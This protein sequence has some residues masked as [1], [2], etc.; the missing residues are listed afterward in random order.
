MFE[1]RYVLM[2]HILKEGIPSYGNRDTITIKANTSISKGATANTSSFAFTNNHIGTHIDVPQHFSDEGKRTYEYPISDYIFSK[3]YI[4]DIP[5]NGG[6]LIDE[7]LF[8]G[9][10]HDIELL[11][12][13]TGFEFNRNLDCYWNNN[14]GLSPSLADFLRCKCPNLCCVGF[15]FISVT[16]WSHHEIG[17]TAHRAFLTPDNGKKEIWIVED[18]K[19]AEIKAPLEQVTIAPMFMEGGNGGAVTVIGKYYV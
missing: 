13:R 3:V 18:M 17:A 5:C 8:G 16:S 19:L 4:A 2:S 7:S 6:E 14:P 9:L 10:P 1:N 15:D 11:L 12:I